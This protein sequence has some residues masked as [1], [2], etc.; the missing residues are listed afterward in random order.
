MGYKIGLNGIDNAA[1]KFHNVRVPVENL[2]NRYCD[3]SEKGEF[4]HDIKGIQQRFFKVTERLLSGRLCIASMT[5]GALK[6]MIYIAMKYSAQRK[7]VSPN[8]LS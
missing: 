4:K 2:M 7:A 3:I 6:T 1:L 8:S 5:I